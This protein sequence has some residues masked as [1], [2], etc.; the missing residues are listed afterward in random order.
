MVRVANLTVLIS[1][2]V[3]PAASAQPEVWRF[4]WHKGQVQTYR[5]AHLTSVVEVVGGSKVESS[6]QLHLVKRWQVLDIDAQGVATL[7]LSLTAL[8]TEQ[9][10]PNGETLLFD[11]ADPDKSTPELREAL[12]KFVG[13]PLAV[14][15]LDN[16]G[17]VVEVKESKFGPRSRYESELPFVLVLPEQAPSAGQTWER[18][19]QITLEP[20]Q[21]TGEHFPAVQKYVCKEVAGEKA[22]VALTTVLP[23]LPESLLDRVPLLQKQP[24]GEVVFD[25]RAGHLHSARL[26]IER[27]LQGHQGTGSSYRFQ[28]T[29]TEEYVESR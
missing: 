24:E 20:P 26:R 1:L 21:G 18:S 6:A 23:K 15:R 19:Y 28:S 13:P 3:V 27:E 5:V 4:Q 9:S 16:R 12:A 7:Q 8:R 25:L 29:Y 14:L 17:Q 10:R 11:S 22:T 2:L